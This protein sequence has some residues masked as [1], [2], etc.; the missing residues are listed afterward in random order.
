MLKLANDCLVPRLSR[1]SS[2]A[3]Q[4]GTIESQSHCLAF[5]T[6]SCLA[7][8]I[9]VCERHAAIRPVTAVPE[10][11][12]ELVAWL[13]DVVAF[14]PVLV[15]EASAVALG[16]VVDAILK[17]RTVAT[18][19]IYAEPTEIAM[20]T[21]S[22]LARSH[23]VAIVARG[24]RDELSQLHSIAPLVASPSAGFA[25]LS[26]LRPRLNS[27]LPEVSRVIESTLCVPEKVRTVQELATRAHKSERTIE[28]V[29]A[30]AGLTTP[31][32]FVDAA[33]LLAA[34][35]ALRKPGATVSGIALSN[36]SNSATLRE[37]SRRTVGVSPRE[38]QRMSH[39]ELAQR[40]AL[41]LTSRS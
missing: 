2:A 14:D 36:V 27:V 19:I 24:A 28:R 4:L 5:L 17:S 8:L 3:T 30:R 33:R 6:P 25:V 18:A 32:S 7:R 21:A 29:L 13:P 37:L 10:L 9:S 40:L 34:Y 23:H 31:R 16:R 26:V 15:A 12:R 11:E 20:R 35:K 1:N 39:R 22:E 41:R 38:L